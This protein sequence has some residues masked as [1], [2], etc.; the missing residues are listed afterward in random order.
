[1]SEY[2]V[3]TYEEAIAKPRTHVW[4]EGNEIHRVSKCSCD[5]CGS[6]RM[7]RIEH[8]N[9]YITAYRND[10]STKERHRLY[11]AYLRKIGKEKCG[12]A[13]LSVGWTGFS[14][15]DDHIAFYNSVKAFCEANGLS[16]NEMVMLAV[17]K[18]MKRRK[19]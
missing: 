3:A 6:I 9:N 2:R 14:Y 18:Y 11:Q 8:R 1:V 16:V 5:K 15:R 4:A 13:S 17:T 7:K 12:I 10:P 19:S